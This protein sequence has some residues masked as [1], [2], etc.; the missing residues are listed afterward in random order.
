[1]DT[2]KN[3]IDKQNNN[4]EK[5]N[6]SKKNNIKGKNSN[7]SKIDLDKFLNKNNNNSNTTFL[8]KPPK[9]DI[10]KYKNLNGLPD[11]L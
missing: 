10:N 11:K 7:T 5:D 8:D 4:T 9:D 1:M 2:N 3:L 6:Y